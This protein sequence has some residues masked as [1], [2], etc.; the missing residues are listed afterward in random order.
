MK[1]YEHTDWRGHHGGDDGRGDDGI[2]RKV[3]CRG[4][5]YPPSDAEKGG[6]GEA[7]TASTRVAQMSTSIIIIIY[8]VR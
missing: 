1:N 6:R 5:F 3:E 8:V 2:H 7:E 4:G